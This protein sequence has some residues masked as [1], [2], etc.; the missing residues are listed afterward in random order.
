MSLFLPVRLRKSSTDLTAA[1]EGFTIS[2]SS[3]KLWYKFSYSFSAMCWCKKNTI[4]SCKPLDVDN[5]TFNMI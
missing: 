2:G 3:K 5:V 4:M 1:A